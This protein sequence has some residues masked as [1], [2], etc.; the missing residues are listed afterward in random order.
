MGGV[1]GVQE[2]GVLEQAEQLTEGMGKVNEVLEAA[3]PLAQFAADNWWIVAVVALGA[4]A[5]IA[6]KVVSARVEDH[7]EGRTS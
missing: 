1:K 4:V 2:T 3:R 5:V 6:G 7:R